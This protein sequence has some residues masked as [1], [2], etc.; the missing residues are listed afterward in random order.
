MDSKPRAA[1]TLYGVSLLTRAAG[2]LPRSVSAGTGSG[3]GMRGAEAPGAAGELRSW[4]WREAIGDKSG[5]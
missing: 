2:S 1:Q 3:L 5:G 4:D